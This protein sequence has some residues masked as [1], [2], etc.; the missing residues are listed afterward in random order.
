MMLDQACHAA[1]QYKILNIT[2]KLTMLRGI[3]GEED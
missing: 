2:L 1:T 3:H